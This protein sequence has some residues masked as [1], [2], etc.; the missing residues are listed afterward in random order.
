MEVEQAGEMRLKAKFYKPKTSIDLLAKSERTFAFMKPQRNIPQS[1]LFKNGE[2]VSK[3]E[4]VEEQMFT[5]FNNFDQ[6]PDEKKKH[7]IASKKLDNRNPTK[8]I[9]KTFTPWIDSE[10]NT[11]TILKQILFAS[12][13]HANG[14]LKHL[15]DEANAKKGQKYKTKTGEEKKHKGTLRLKISAD[16]VYGKCTGILQGLIEIKKVFVSDDNGID[17]SGLGVF[18]SSNCVEHFNEQIR[19]LKQF[20]EL[21]IF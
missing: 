19:M 4:V 21:E 18:F 8:R 14:K 10:L 16:V 3:G 11:V 12:G 13:Y 5:T 6:K 7:W 17:N 15:V 20:S 2:R 9:R 1:E